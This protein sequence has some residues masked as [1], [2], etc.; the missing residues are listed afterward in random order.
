MRI[1]LLII[2]LLILALL[3]GIIYFASYL[4]C[5]DSGQLNCASVWYVWTFLIPIILGIILTAL[6][7]LKRR[8]KIV[9]KLYLGLG[10]FIFCAFVLINVLGTLLVYI[11]A[12]LQ[13]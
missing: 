5:S 3:A 1:L 8:N 10:L 7:F 6:F 9:D 2:D 13:G 4:A 12:Y 11:H